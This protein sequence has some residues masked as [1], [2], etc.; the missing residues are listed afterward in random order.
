MRQVLLGILMIGIAGIAKA[1]T[2][3]MQVP[4]THIQS[5]P[6][7]TYQNNS[8]FYNK[9]NHATAV[10]PGI[11]TT[12]NGT[13]WTPGYSNDANRNAFSHGLAP[14]T[15]V[16]S[17]VN[18]STNSYNNTTINYSNPNTGMN[19]TNRVTPGNIN[20]NIYRP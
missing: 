15:S 16:N 17:S 10:K 6:N 11:S 19:N 8:Q 14:N 1:Q 3:A 13:Y 20:S 9:D 4:A 2:G 5:P 18:T 7:A 12:G